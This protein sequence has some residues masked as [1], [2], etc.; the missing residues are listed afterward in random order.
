MGLAKIENKAIL[1][2]TELQQAPSKCRELVKYGWKKGCTGQCKCFNIQNLPWH[3]AN[4]KAFA[5]AYL[6][7][8][9]YDS[10]IKMLRQLNS[11]KYLKK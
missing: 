7:F 9:V 2:W 4:V 11:Q 3:S 5:K 8:I 6:Y 1:L 10:A